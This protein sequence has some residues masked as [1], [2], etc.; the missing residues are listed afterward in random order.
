MVCCWIGGILSVNLDMSSNN[1]HA[2][3]GERLTLDRIFSSNEFNE[4][5][6]GAI[7]WSTVSPSYFT[8]EKKTPEAAGPDLVRVD[9]ETGTKEVVVPSKYLVPACADKPLG[10]SS[11]QFTA[12]E[13]K[14]LLYTNS[15]KVWRQNTR[16]D[17]WLLD[18]KTPRLVKLG[19]DIAAA[20]MMF[21]KLSPDQSMVGYVHEHNLYVQALDT[22]Q[23][24][25]LTK[26][27]SATLING[28]SDWVNE[29][30]LAIRDGWRW[31]PDSKSIAFYQFDTTGVPL[32]HMIDYGQ[33]NYPKIT[34]FPYPKVGEKNSST[35]IGV[36]DVTGANPR[37][38]ELPGDSREHYIP[39]V[40][41]TPAGDALLIQQMNRPQNRNDVFLADPQSMAPRPIFTEV[42]EAWIENENP[43]RWLDG[44]KRFLWISERSGWRHAYLASVAGGE[45]VPVTQGDFDII[46]IET[47]DEA[48]GYLYYAASPDNAT[49][50]YLFRVK[51]SGGPPER[52]TP[53][54]QAGWH[55]YQ[56]APNHQFAVHTWSNL[57]TPPRTEIIRLPGHEVVRTLA[58]NQSLKEKLA[59]WKLPQAELFRVDIG[60]GVEL[61]GWRYAPPEIKGDRKHPVFF[62][63]YGEPH[64]QVV[65][66]AWTGKRGLWYAMLAQEG[67]LVAAVDNRGTMSPRGR[68][69][70]KCVYK[71]V[72]ILASQEQAAAVKALLKQWPHADPARVGI[73]GWSGGGSMSLNVLFRSPD[74]YRMAIAVAPMPDQKLYDTIYQER[75]M[76]LLEDNREGYRLGSPTTFARQLQ[77]KLLIVHGTGDDNCHYQAT[78]QL[79][80]ELIAFGKQF[81]VM[82]Y[83]SRS[84]SI[85]EGRGTSKHLYEL[86]TKFL[87][88]N[89]PVADDKSGKDPQTTVSLPSHEERDVSGWTVRIDRRLLADQSAKLA[90]ALELLKLQLDEIVRVVPPRAV[91]EL[92][93]VTLWMSPEYKGVSPKA[94]YHPGRDWLVANGRLPEMA[95]GV[96]FTNIRI[97]EEETR[98][99]PN[100]ALHELAHAYHD[101]V[102]KGGFGNSDVTRAY[103]AAKESKKY[104]LVEQRLADGRSIQSKAYA[105][106]NPMEYFA[107]ASEA[108]FVKNDF[109]P[110]DRE[111]LLQHDPTV[112]PVLK[113]LW[114]E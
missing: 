25:P 93:K 57:V 97:F 99:M 83:P 91:G 111:E 92:R 13:S 15:Q 58:D 105:L 56:I 10:I 55:T 24:T 82:P 79:M 76:G 59:A 41:W 61:D 27:G 4:E 29:E 54:D 77:G 89:L 75:Y 49:Q 3:E 48:G 78:E 88:E 20:S 36:I 64:G 62:H 6:V 17:Y 110:F 84:H 86:M 34:T 80:N 21:A 33:G 9:I 87:H 66:D 96:E 103:E 53:A 45:L 1:A 2:A 71:Q 90:W 30:E 43:V 16:G 74:V 46:D 40:E 26:D 109:A 47:V 69:F 19:G 100:F 8:W 11:Y 65:K 101:R 5:R 68:A 52:V 98:R 50:R 23:V 51:L 108:Y 12:D 107:E 67:Y 60:G 94:E 7:Q 32:F 31:S 38:F 73:W 63:V 18:L 35:R 14:L 113:Q 85:S 106:T 114:G 112:V 28:T 42:D 104:D 102:L 81:S 22:L 95:K 70:R 44:G 72:G 39:R 37:W